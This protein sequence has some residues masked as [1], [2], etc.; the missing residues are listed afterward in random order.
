MY[1]DIR[2]GLLLILSFAL[3]GFST[4]SFAQNPPKQLDKVV[5]IVNDQAI[6]YS[7]FDK[8]MALAKKNIAEQK[9]NVPT[10][11][12]A[13]QVMQTLIQEQAII[14][15]AKAVGIY[16]PKE[17]IKFL[18]SQQAEAEGKNYN[19]FIQEMGAKGVTAADL[20]RQVALQ[21]LI[22]RINSQLISPSIKV[23]DTEIEA[24]L[25]NSMG[26]DIRSATVEVNLAHIV[27]KVAENANADARQ[28]ARNKAEKAFAEIVAGKEFSDV[29]A[30][31]SD[32][33]DAK[34]GGIMGF[35]PISRLPD[36]YE[37]TQ[38][39]LQEGQVSQ[40]FESPNGYHIIKLIGKRE[41]TSQKVERIRASHILIANDLGQ[42]N[43]IIQ[44][45]ISIKKQLSQG[46]DFASLAKKYSVDGSAK[47]GGDLGWLY[48]GDTVSEFEEV[49]SKL[50]IGEVS[51]PVLTQFGWHIIKVNARETVPLPY[52]K[53]KQLARR[54]ISDEK[55][56]REFNKWVED[57]VAATYI[58]IIQTN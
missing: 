20:E 42:E 10:Q 8:R 46:G 23:T 54:V 4:S 50:K 16:P 51:E 13:S 41:N 27:I 45:L 48:P 35:R 43:D 28:N 52:D 18:L 47:N 30:R 58:K 1:I 36:I 32:F 37:K 19:K 31:Y 22:S 6:T 26:E 57:L 53:A 29:A 15:Y 25:L 9:L 12:V 17:E 2:S 33:S 11:A 55:V 24:F 5:A 34:E 40:I 38:A 14:Q 49:L 7:E 21:V 3:V 44:K 56:G 39:G